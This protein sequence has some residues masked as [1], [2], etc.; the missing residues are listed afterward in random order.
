MQKQKSAPVKKDRDLM[1][2]KVNVSDVLLNHWEGNY[3]HFHRN[4]VNPSLL[5][6][7]DIGNTFEFKGRKFKIIG[8]T[9][10]WTM[11]V[12]E[13]REP[14]QAPVYWECSR[15]FVQFCLDRKVQ[16][17]FKLKGKL[18]SRPRD[19][20]QIDLFLPPISVMKK[21]KL[22]KEEEEVLDTQPKFEIF[23][24]DN[25]DDNYNKDYEE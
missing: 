5:K 2:Q 15:Y 14:N 1:R 6:L 16:E 8:M 13:I 10:V 20:R 18:H 11:I 21:I 17:Y 4:I 7:E 3:R 23:H 22:E 25:S 9:F 24:E 12:E 19:Y